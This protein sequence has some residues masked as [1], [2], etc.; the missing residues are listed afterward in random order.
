MPDFAEA[1]LQMVE[2]QLRTREVT[3][4]GL[5]SAMLD[6]PRERFLPRARAELA[7][8]D[9]RHELTGTSR[10][11]LPAPEAFARLAQLGGITHDDVVLDVACGT[12][13]S[14]AVLARIASAV[15]ALEDDADLV[16]E[17]D[18][19]LTALEV[20]NAAVLRGELGA[21]VPTEAPFD[22]IVV[23]GAIDA[24]PETLFSQLKQG[25]RLVAGV[26]H[27][28][29]VVATLFVRSEGVVTRNEAFD[30]GLPRLAAFAAPPAFAL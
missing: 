4:R 8:S 23:E 18:S 30:I 16:A 14:T 17:A 24:I 13:Y 11:T 28:P 7:Y 3:D 25:G 15:V 21:G 20:G 5:L 19:L 27:G 2:T 26:A 9:M 12:G 1:R 22:V 29:T 6:V 10:R